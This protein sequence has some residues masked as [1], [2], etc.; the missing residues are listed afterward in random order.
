MQNEVYINRLSFFVTVIHST[1]LRKSVQFNIV[2]N[3]SWGHKSPLDSLLTVD[4]YYNNLINLHVCRTFTQKLSG[5]AQVD[6][7][8][9]CKSLKALP[10]VRGIC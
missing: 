2:R 4:V 7:V 9:G 1:P 5:Q 6:T 8:K 3:I 10:L